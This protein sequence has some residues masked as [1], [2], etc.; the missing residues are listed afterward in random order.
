MFS[1]NEMNSG[2][3]T[4]SL[5]AGKHCKS[6]LYKYK[7]SYGHVFSHAIS[8]LHCINQFIS[9]AFCGSYLYDDTIC[10]TF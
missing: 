9:F 3:Y 6:F 8:K 10:A 2:M 1:F 7:Y 5:V 4:I